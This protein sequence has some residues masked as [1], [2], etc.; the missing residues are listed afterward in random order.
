MTIRLSSF[1]LRVHP[2]LP[3]LWLLACAT[4][5]GIRLLP[6]LLA[7][8]LHE[9][10]HLIAAKCLQMPLEE[11]ELTPF[12]GLITLGNQDAAS[13]AAQFLLALAGPLFSFFGCLAAGALYRRG[14]VS[15]PFASVFA[16]ANLLLLLFNLLPALP[17][18]GGRMLQAAL[19]R[20]F[21]LAAVKRVLSAAAYGWGAAFCALTLIFAFQGRIVLSPAFAGLYLIYAAA[22]EN[23]QATA[24]YVTALIARRTRLE[25]NE[26]LPIQAMA[27]GSDLPAGKLLG[28]LHPGKYHMIHVLSRD[29][30][31]LLGEIDEETL[32]EACLSHPGTPLCEIL[33]KNRRGPR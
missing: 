30:M 7:L 32:C 13:P 9:S 27:A 20:F 19:S 5:A 16:R 14:Q 22:S 2:L 23:R 12:G 18:D 31:R 24:R 21:P 17:L 29:G 26:V 28:R 33:N 11:V 10:G 4:G 8:L 3:F 6:M 1:R 15:F 25:K